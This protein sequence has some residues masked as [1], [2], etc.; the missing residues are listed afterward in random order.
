[1]SETRHK[2]AQ[3]KSRDLCSRAGLT[4]SECLEVI[5][6]T[7]TIISLV[8]VLYLYLLTGTIL[9]LFIKILHGAK[10]GTQNSTC[11][12]VIVLMLSFTLEPI[13]KKPKEVIHFQGS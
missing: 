5:R 6:L 1:M 3:R 8:M 12:V 11:T 4:Y 13:K 2:Q 9:I 10:Q 7:L